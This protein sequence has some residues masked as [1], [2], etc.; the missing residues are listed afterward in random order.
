MR[1]IEKVD[2]NGQLLYCRFEPL[3]AIGRN[4]T[5]WWDF[6]KHHADDGKTYYSYQ[7]PDA[8][9]RLLTEYDATGTEIFSIF[10]PKIKNRKL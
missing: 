4:S 5:G 8:N 9:N 10:V 1:L 6:K 2:N 3:Q 7:E